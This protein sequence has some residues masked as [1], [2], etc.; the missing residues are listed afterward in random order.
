[1]EEDNIKIVAEMTEIPIVGQVKVGD[2]ELDMSI[3]QLV[4][5]FHSKE[6]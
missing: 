3:H 1:M 5:F 6:D 4:S 2:T